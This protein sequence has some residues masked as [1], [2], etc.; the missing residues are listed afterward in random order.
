MKHE[1]IAMECLATGLVC[2]SMVKYL[3]RTTYNEQRFWLH[4]VALDFNPSTWEAESAQSLSLKPSW[5][6][7]Y[8]P[9]QPKLQSWDPLSKSQQLQNRSFFLSLFG[10]LRNPKSRDQCLARNW[11]LA[12]IVLT[13]TQQ[14]RLREARIILVCAFRGFSRGHL[15]PV[16]GQN[17][18]ATSVCSPSLD[19]WEV[20]G[21]PGRDQEYYTPKDP[22]PVT[23]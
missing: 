13:H 22:P 1:E 10:L 19:D 4:V 15:T 14:K 7:W 17:I 5:P 8:A 20:V 2:I 21:V 9:G 23:Y 6:T 11:H 12:R 3:T 16:V 18:I